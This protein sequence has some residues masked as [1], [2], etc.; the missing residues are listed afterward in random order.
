[1]TKPLDVLILGAGCAGLSLA[2][3]LAAQGGSAPRVALLD[4]RTGYSDDRTWCFWRHRGAQI[5][6]L[7]SHE[8]SRLE[9]ASD[10]E[11]YS[12]D[13]SAA[14]YAMIRSIDFYRDAVARIDGNAHLQ[15]FLGR[16]ALGE[17]A[18]QEGR[19]VVQTPAGPLEAFK[20]V[21]TRPPRALFAGAALV[22]QSFLGMEVTI[23]DARSGGGLG[24]D[25]AK[26][27]LMDFRGTPAGR[28]VFTYLLPL[29]ETR[30]LVE[31]TELSSHP[32]TASDL[33]AEW[34]HAL[35]RRLGGEPFQ[36]ERQE[37]GTL[38]M[39]IQVSAS[40]G[41]RRRSEMARSMVRAGSMAGALRPSTG[42]AFQRIQQWAEACAGRLAEGGDPIGHAPDP[43][44]MR[45]MD[46]LF[47]RVLRSRP[48]LAPELFTS[49]F[50]K[51]APPAMIR[52]LNDRATVFDLAAVAA[53]LPPGPFLKELAGVCRRKASAWR[54]SF[55]A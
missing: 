41:Q 13:C 11:S 8:W 32:R 28:I 53:G 24:W 51:V 54:E 45:G 25:P 47:L 52:F 17:V 48:E 6:H 9:V 46:T 14:P 19:W 20:V 34:H 38:P 5:T 10:A 2:A 55:A 18:R 37:F 26:A 36:V 43:W 30:A 35:R 16:P 33:K 4:A 7:V 21:D 27:V 50:G 22:W 39:G 15:R 42:Y 31:V 12:V 44:W 29:S 40:A 1:M 49:M 23:A 3:R